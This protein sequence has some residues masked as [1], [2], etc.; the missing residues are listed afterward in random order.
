MKRLHIALAN[1]ENL[2]PTLLRKYSMV[3]YVPHTVVRRLSLGERDNRV[4]IVNET[5]FKSNQSLREI[6][7]IRAILLQIFQK[8]KECLVI[9]P[10]YYRETEIFIKSFNRCNI[11][12]VVWEYS[13]ERQ[14]TPFF[15]DWCEE[16]CAAIDLLG[17]FTDVPL[18]QFALRPPI[19]PAI[20]ERKRISL[21]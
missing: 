6:D 15:F 21:N 11:H 4:F 17:G 1:D 20:L 10:A 5:C 9:I 16:T 3:A 14:L 18:D 8:K 19:S 7:R 2:P 13:E 12:A